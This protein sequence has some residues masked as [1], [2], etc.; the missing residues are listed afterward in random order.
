[1]GRD[2]RLKL[3]ETLAVGIQPFQIRIIERPQEYMRW[4]HRTPLTQWRI[5]DGIEG[6][7]KI[8]L[9]DGDLIEVPGPVRREVDAKML[10]HDGDGFGCGWVSSLRNPGTFGMHAC[11]E[12]GRSDPDCQG[13]AT[14]IPNADKQEPNRTCYH[15]SL[16]DAHQCFV[17]AKASVLLTIV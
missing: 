7:Q 11:T 10:L 2:S 15:P 13:T 17:I 6:N 9:S 4:G 14:G 3:G 1:M 5:D 12:E 8:E 16:H